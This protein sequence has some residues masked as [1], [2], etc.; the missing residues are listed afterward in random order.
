[1]VPSNA[2][3]VWSNAKRCGVMLIKVRSNAKRCG[4]MLKGAE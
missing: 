1:M 3:K 4:V 2:R